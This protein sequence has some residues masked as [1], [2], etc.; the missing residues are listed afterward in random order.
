M[1]NQW[2]LPVLFSAVTL[3]FYDIC[4][5]NSVKDNSV[6]PVLFL[7]TLCGTGFFLAVTAVSGQLGNVIVCTV[8][9]YILT[10]LKSVIVS[11]SWVC[12]FYAMRELPITLASPI[13]A[14]S[15][16]WTVIGGLLIFHEIPNRMQAVG[17]VIIFAGYI[18]FNLIGKAEGF[19]WKSKGLIL[20]IAG[21]LL[22]AISALF[23]KYLLN[24][25]KIDRQMLQFY[26]S[27]NLVAVLGGAWAIRSCFGQK[28]PFKWKWSIPLTGILLIMADYAYF[29]ALSVDN[30]PISMVSLVRRCSC[31]V[32]FA[33][34]ARF[35]KDSRLKSKAAALALL[36]L[37]VIL[38]ALGK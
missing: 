19:N 2:F 26:F 37:G 11:A 27:V 28:H 18:C 31:V 5:K 7:A 20:I 38:I 10:L 9:E 14:T 17:M 21:T 1:N 16:L 22:G 15:P 24:T 25:V 6:M 8:P 4:K 30:A 3:G 33:I 36:L 12:V 13:R 29:Y 23:D 35:F 34:G 32:T